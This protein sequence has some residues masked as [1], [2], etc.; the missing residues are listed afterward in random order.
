MNNFI[1]HSN[2]DLE[3]RFLMVFISSDAVNGMRTILSK[4][5]PIGKALKNIVKTYTFL[6]WMNKNGQIHVPKED[7]VKMIYTDERHRNR[8]KRALNILEEANLIKVTYNPSNKGQ[9]PYYTYKTYTFEYNHTSDKEEIFEYKIPI[10]SCFTLFG[11]K[12]L[13]CLINNNQPSSFSHIYPTNSLS[14]N[15]IDTFEKQFLGWYDELSFGNMVVPTGRFSEKDKRFYQYFHTMPKEERLSTVM[16][17]GEHVVEVWDAHSA[18]FIVMGYYLKYFKEYETEQERDKFIKEADLMMKLAVNDRLY[19][20]LQKYHNEHALSPVTCITRDGMKK[21][22]Q[23]YISKSYKRLFN[24][25]GERTKYLDAQWCRYIDEYF[26]RNFPNIRLWILNYP[27]HKEIKDVVDGNGM[28]HKNQLVSV[29]E[30]H[31]DIM[32]FEFE[33][34]SIGLCKDIYK[35]FKIKSVTVH[36][37]IY[38]KT[39][40][41]DKISSSKIDELLSERLGICE[42]APRS[43][44]LF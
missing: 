36:D 40:D 38:M 5:K 31:H 22:V 24:T 21:E 30:I 32:P 1:L 7:L 28:T 9:K 2:I 37:A 18:F 10:N 17:N 35:L 29:S 6:Y 33:L 16:W 26:Q 14:Y 15:N 39:S 11:E 13:S 4:D 20:S 34:V 41:A 43:Y 27:R 19:S 44:A 23:R 25:N 42:K 12:F 8:F 3:N